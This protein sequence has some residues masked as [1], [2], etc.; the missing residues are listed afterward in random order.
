[1]NIVI[2]L[3]NIMDVIKQLHMKAIRPHSYIY[4]HIHFMN[5]VKVLLSFYPCTEIVL[6]LNALGTRYSC[7]PNMYTVCT[8]ISSNDVS[9]C[10]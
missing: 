3:L 9:H 6:G 7:A 8:S 4:L 1:M 2:D 10:F 5:S